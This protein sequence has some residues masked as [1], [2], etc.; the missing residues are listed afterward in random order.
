MVKGYTN[1]IFFTKLDI[2]LNLK[3]HYIKIDQT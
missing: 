2:L 3:K 1:C